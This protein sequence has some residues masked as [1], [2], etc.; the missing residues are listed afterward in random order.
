MGRKMTGMERFAFEDNQYPFT[1][2]THVRDIA[3]GIV[4]D[5][6]G[7]VAIHRIYRDDMFGAQG[8]YETPG[9]GVDEGESFE[10]AFV[11]ECEEEIGCEVEILSPLCDVK[12]FYNLIGREN[13]NRFFLAI[14]V[15]QTHKHFASD[16]DQMIQ[17]TLWIPIQEAISKYEAQEQ[18]GVAGLVRQREL[19][20]LRLAYEEMVRQ[21][22][23]KR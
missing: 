22:L 23:C 5:E 4:V 17:E 7:N 10:Q 18:T 16:G 21:G 2:V 13:H 11:R 9:G 19:P 1:G 15:K 12:D 8:Y 14:K 20:A 6:E 3:R